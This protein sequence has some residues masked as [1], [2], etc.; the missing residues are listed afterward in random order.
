MCGNSHHAGHVW[1][2]RT[3]PYDT[4]LQIQCLKKIFE[5]T[6]QQQP[7]KDPSVAFIARPCYYNSLL[8][9]NKLLCVLLLLLLMQRLQQLNEA[10]HTWNALNGSSCLRSMFTLAPVTFPPCEVLIKD[11]ATALK[12][13]QAFHYCAFLHFFFSAIYC[14]A[15]VINIVNVNRSQFELQDLGQR[16]ANDSLSCSSSS[17]SLLSSS[18]CVRAP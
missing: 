9:D 14:T 12:C 4:Q 7:D 5:N 1:G 2:R 13:I 10:A 18:R 11:E 17:P 6:A 15:C 16:L 8:C 3:L